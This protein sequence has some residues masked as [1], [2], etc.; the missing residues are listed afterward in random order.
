MTTAKTKYMSGMIISPSLFVGS[1]L[2]SHLR[3]QSKTPVK[4][5]FV[6]LWK[7]SM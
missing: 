4:K 6:L 2:L 1:V 7:A 5:Q 3:H